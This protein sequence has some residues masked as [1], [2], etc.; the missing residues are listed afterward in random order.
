VVYTVEAVSSAGCIGD[1]RTITITIN[2]EPVI[3]TTLSATVCSDLTLGLTL[4]TNGSSVAAANYNVT[5]RTISAGLTA[6][7]TNAAVPGTAVAA[8]YLL[9]DRFTNTGAL[10]LTVTYTVVGVSADGC[11][12]NPQVITIT[13]NPEPVVSA[14]LDKSVCS[15]TPLAL[16]L[17]T[18][19]SSVAAA[20]YDITARSVAVGLSP[21]VGNAA[22]PASGVGVNYLA[23]DEFTNTGNTPLTVGYTVVPISAD[24]CLGDPR[25]VTVTINPEP[26]VATSLNAPYAVIRLRALFLIP[27]GCRLRLPIITLQL[28][29]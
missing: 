12:G 15:D 3:A 17:N 8:N 27:T 24:G 4:N 22:A 20:S 2:P 10:P 18:N 14:T 11:V 16:T 5:A 23:S 13:I 28:P 21:A 1:Q 29:P 19:G 7:V 6:A 9:N 25:I 26:V